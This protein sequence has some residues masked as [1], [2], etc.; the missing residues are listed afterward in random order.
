MFVK[1]GRCFN[2]IRGSI[3]IADDGA[4]VIVYL[5]NISVEG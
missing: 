4:N 5:K 3:Y 2:K 1:C